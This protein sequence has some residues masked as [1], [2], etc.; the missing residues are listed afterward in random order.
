MSHA[1]F[2]TQ[3]TFFQEFTD[4]HASGW[5]FQAR[6]NRAF[7]PFRRCGDA[8]SV[9]QGFARACRRIGDTGGR[10]PAR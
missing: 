6:G 10:E 4:G 7:G 2:P 9:V 5:F 3:R 1:H 8:Q